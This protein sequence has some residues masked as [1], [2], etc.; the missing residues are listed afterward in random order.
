MNFKFAFN[1]EVL[2]ADMLIIHLKLTKQRKKKE[3]K[4][5]KWQPPQ[6]NNKICMTKLQT[7]RP[8]KKDNYN[9]IFEI[10]GLG[11]AW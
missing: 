3:E 8:E 6:K 9:E 11:D 10:M 2:A 1:Y 7:R 4:N 5:R